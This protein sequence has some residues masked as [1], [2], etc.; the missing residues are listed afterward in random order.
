MT[1]VITRN[2]DNDNKFVVVMMLT[3]LLMLHDEVNDEVDKND[4][5]DL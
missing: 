5:D 3:K 1:I 4:D 2:T